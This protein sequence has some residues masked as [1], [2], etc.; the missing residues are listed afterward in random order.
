MSRWIDQRGIAQGE[1]RVLP[2]ANP[3]RPKKDFDD[4]FI[5]YK[6]PWAK[7]SIMLGVVC[8]NSASSSYKLN[9]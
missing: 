5:E 8:S 4:V 1:F 3:P 2:T 6:C 9:I 7:V